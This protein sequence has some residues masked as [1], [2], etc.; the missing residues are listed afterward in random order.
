M[1][2]TIS[3]KM[4]VKTAEKF[5]V[6]NAPT[7]LTIIGSAG[8]IATAYLTGK[9]TFKA[10]QIIDNEQFQRNIQH[11]G[12]TPK[13]EITNK[14]KAKLV[15][16]EY[17]PPAAVCVGA[18][19]AGIFAN[20]I[21]TKR[22]A[23]LAAA[24]ALSQDRFGEYKEKMQE[25]LGVKKEQ[26]ATDELVQ[27]RVS[28]NPPGDNIVII[29]SGTVLCR[30]ELSGRYFKSTVEAIKRA[31][32][33]INREIINS[34]YAT[35]S[36]FYERI[37]LNPTSMSE[38]FGW[39]VPTKPLELTWSTVLTSDDQPCAC[40]DYNVEPLKAYGACAAD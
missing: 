29:G 40:F 5:V 12:P 8:T 18:V 34:G 30:D 36:D 17:I 20:R 11:V 25:K 14:E 2:S 9:A 23:A 38:T 27:E 6:D 24:Y 16:K 33:D 28:K 4:L 32:N 19:S 3:S 26:A 39:N 35:L 13:P 37:G 21:S 10:A 31:E 22:A 15:W 1:M 7:I